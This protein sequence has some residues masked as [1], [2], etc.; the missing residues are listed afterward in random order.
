[1]GKWPNT[2]AASKTQPVHLNHNPLRP[3]RLIPSSS[4]LRASVPQAQRVVKFLI[5]TSAPSA[6]S[7]VNLFNP[8]FYSV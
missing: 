8:A 5:L 1:V 7:V 6:S 2:R 3:L 4:F